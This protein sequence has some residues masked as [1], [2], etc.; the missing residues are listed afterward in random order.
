[1]TKKRTILSSLVVSLALIAS[2]SFSSCNKSESD[3]S[4]PTTE[5]PVESKD[6]EFAICPHCGGNIYAG[7]THIHYF[8]P[9][10]NCAYSFCSWNGRY[11][12]HVVRFNPGHLQDD[13]EHLGGGTNNE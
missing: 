10:E 7:E 12:R 6:P 3:Q 9:D 1:M 13:W 8:L 4:V 2:M 11:H 5:E